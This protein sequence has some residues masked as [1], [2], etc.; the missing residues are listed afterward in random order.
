MPLKKNKNKKTN[1]ETEQEAVKEKDSVVDLEDVSQKRVVYAEIDDEVTVIY[2]KVRKVSA[3]N[4]YVVVPKRA[5]LFQ[6][7]VNL[8]ILKRKMEDDGKN[9]YFITNDKNGVYL[10]QQIGI[11]VYNKVNTEGKPALFSAET[12]DEKLRIT[13]LRAT[14][15][16]VE[17]EAPTRLA[18]RKLSISEI[19][20]KKF[21]N[22]PVDVKKLDSPTKKKESRK[23]VIVAPNRHALIGL[24]VVTVFVLLSIAYVALPGVTVYLTPSASVIEK[25][26]NITLADFNRNR[27]ELETRP[28][29]V[30]A[31][32]PIEVTVKKTIVHYST[33]KKFS[34]RGANS[35]GIITIVN[36]TGNSWPLIAN[37]RFQTDDGIVFRI[38][39]PI[40]VPAA[41]KNGPGKIETIVTADQVDAYGVIIGERGNVQPTKFFLP[42][43]KEDSRSKI[44]A[45]SAKPMTGGVT[46]YTSFIAK[47]DVEAAKL[48]LKDELLKNATEELRLAVS[49]SAKD[50]SG[51]VVYT[52]LEGEG[53]IKIGEVKMDIPQGL[54]NRE[55]KEFSLSGEVHVSGVYYDH[56]EMIEIL[57]SELLLK[58]SPQKELLRVNE[59]TTS[60][61]IF[62]W[63][64][65][66]GKIKLTANIK[67]IEQFLID[68]EKEN[69]EKLLNKIREHISGK[70]V[71]DAKLFIQNLPEINKV[72][73]ESWPVWSPTIPTLTENIDFEIRD[74]LNAE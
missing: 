10:A 30:I 73:I 17:E 37:T 16:S 19:L 24:I 59:S 23:F 39:S 45:E 46:D 4:V 42:G 28:P 14:V 47:E 25:S 3:K 51:T 8:K 48:R 36:T 56:D 63:D 29:H 6:S 71:E 52:L 53:A 21:V 65:D 18:E 43:L 31:S 32:Y 35:S 58:K 38:S 11:I 27:G 22:K 50:S 1:E 57:K 44:Y 49:E 54:E 61:R 72:E 2:D 7:V 62:E 5:I 13:P 64:A 41:D 74:A 15:N 12:D 60:Y 70:D 67:G 40:T 55:A 20:K 33:G 68:P 69:G 34:D 9:L 26:I 66:A